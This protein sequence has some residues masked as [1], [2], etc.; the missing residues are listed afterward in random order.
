M[1]GAAYVVGQLA[2]CQLYDEN[3]FALNA[4]IEL[5]EEIAFYLNAY[6][7]DTGFVNRGG[8][9]LIGNLVLSQIV[10][11]SFALNSQIVELVSADFDLNSQLAKDIAASSFNMDMEMIKTAFG[12]T[13]LSKKSTGQV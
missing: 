8:C 11:S 13:A 9:P 5:T 2:T 4:Q 6:L 3:S 12:G 7:K 10:A 1:A